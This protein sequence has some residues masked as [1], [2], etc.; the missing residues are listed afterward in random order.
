MKCARCGKEAPES[1]T[2]EAVELDAGGLLVVRHIPCYR[3]GNCGEVMYAGDVVRR[4]EELTGQAEA[5]LQEITVG[6]Y[7][8][9][10]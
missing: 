4:M 2:T 6:N 7:A 9:T 3:C 5:M 10:R 1:L 8:R